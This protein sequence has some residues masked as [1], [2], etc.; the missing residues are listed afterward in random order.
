MADLET[1]E[2][3]DVL[4][5]IGHSRHLHGDESLLVQDKPQHGLLP[6]AYE[7]M[8]TFMWSHAGM[9]EPALAGKGRQHQ[10]K[11]RWRQAQP[12]PLHNRIQF[13]HHLH[14]LHAGKRLSGVAGNT[15][16]SIHSLDH[17]GWERRCS[18]QMD[19]VQQSPG[20]VWLDQLSDVPVALAVDQHEADSESGV[21]EAALLRRGIHR[22]YW[23]VM[24]DNKGH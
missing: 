2:A 13:A 24:A 9:G 7:G 1:Q 12:Y 16:N 19:T 15:S 23:L 20:L 5:G 21:T 17:H 3:C 22:L 11:V 6:T 4:G 8:G 10:G 14:C 18:E